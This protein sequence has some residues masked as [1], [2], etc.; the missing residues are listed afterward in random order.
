MVRRRVKQSTTQFLNV[1]LDVDATSDLQPLVNAFGKKVIVLHAGR[2]RRRYAIH[3]E[4]ARVTKTADATIRGFCALIESLSKAG[5]D[6]WNGAK[7]R[8]FNI[9]VQAG[10][11]PHCCEFALAVETLKAASELGA[12]IVFTVYAAEES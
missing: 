6:L 8:E 11:Q 3:L 5:R 1:D 7:V 10:T 9:G 4:L 12:R 2:I